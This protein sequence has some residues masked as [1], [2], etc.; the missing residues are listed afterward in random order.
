METKPLVSICIP[1]YNAEKFIGETIKCVLDQTYQNFEIIIT[2]NCS[3][4]NT[5]NVVLSFDDSR[6]KYYNNGNNLGA[7]ANWNKSLKLANGKYIKLLCADDIIY[8]DCLTEQVN[9]FEDPEYSNLSLVTTNKN[10]I[11][12]DGKIIM[13]KKFPG[14]KG[15]LNGLKALKKSI[16]FGTNIIGEPVAGLFKKDILEK[17]GYYRGNNLYLIDLDLWSRMLLF[18]DLYV[19]DKVLYGFR[20]STT[21]LSTNIGFG[22]IKLFNTFVAKLYADK[23]FKINSIDKFIG[24]L[25]ALLMGIARNLVYL[26][27]FRK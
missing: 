4:D 15:Y 10:V 6:I 2:D 19:I 16:W 11:N 21:S 23:R 18:G 3:D 9:I 8:P 24:W 17:S 5:Q 22:Q 7:E 13:Q 20:I 1:V 14:K 25:M 12:Q 27:Y 26:I